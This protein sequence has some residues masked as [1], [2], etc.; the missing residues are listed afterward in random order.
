M[1]KLLNLGPKLGR[2]GKGLVFQKVNCGNLCLSFCLFLAPDELSFPEK[3]RYSATLTLQIS[4]IPDSLLSV[5]L[6]VKINILPGPPNCCRGCSEAGKKY[7][8]MIKTSFGEKTVA[9]SAAATRKSWKERK[10]NNKIIPWLLGEIKCFELLQICL[11]RQGR[12]ITQHM[13]KPMKNLTKR[14]FFTFCLS[15]SHLGKSAHFY[16]PLNLITEAVSL[17]PRTWIRFAKSLLFYAQ[18]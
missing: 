6:V 18:E 11:L 16:F 7:L 9:T 12:E 14:D 3:K 5:A 4:K 1:Q 10:C 17:L 13:C 2:G 8:F 15:I